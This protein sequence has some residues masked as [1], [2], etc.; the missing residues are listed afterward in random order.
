MFFK[1]HKQ[2][3][4]KEP[5][6]LFCWVFTLFQIDLL[7]EWDLKVLSTGTWLVLFVMCTVDLNCTKW[8]LKRIEGQRVAFLGSPSSLN[9]AL[10]EDYLTDIWSNLLLVGLTDTQSEYHYLETVHCCIILL[11]TNNDNCMQVAN[12]MRGHP[13][14]IQFVMYFLLP[15]IMSSIFLKTHTWWSM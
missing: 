5:E 4:T 15:T 10:W 9:W 14:Y 7:T 2:V 1:L 12:K 8:L 11:T 6:C 3:C 13:L